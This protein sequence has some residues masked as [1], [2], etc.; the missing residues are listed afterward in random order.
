MTQIA[1]TVAMEITLP[2]LNDGAPHRDRNWNG[3]FIAAEPFGGFAK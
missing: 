1:V 2:A 3:S